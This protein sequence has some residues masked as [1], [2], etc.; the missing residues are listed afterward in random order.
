MPFGLAL[1][2]SFEL[3][4]TGSCAAGGRPFPRGALFHVDMGVRAVIT[5]LGFPGIVRQC[6]IR[7]G[8]E[9]RVGR[10]RRV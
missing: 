9:Y 4:G 7:Q 5:M 8:N 3:S 10:L 1:Y 6:L 2:Y